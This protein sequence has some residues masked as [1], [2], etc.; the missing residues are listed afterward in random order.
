MDG[1]GDVDYAGEWLRMTGKEDMVMFGSSYPHWH[2]GD[3]R[4]LPSAWSDEQRAKVLSGNAAA[5]YG[6]SGARAG[7]K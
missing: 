6:L 7:S 4:C 1:P 2:A 5:L 3:H